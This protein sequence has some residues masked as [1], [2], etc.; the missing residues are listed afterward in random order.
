VDKSYIA[1]NIFGK[2]IG[3]V[4]TAIQVRGD[5]KQ[6][7]IARNRLG[8]SSSFAIANQN[9]LAFA[10]HCLAD[11]NTMTSGFTV[12][13]QDITFRNNRMKYEPI[14][15]P[16]GERPRGVTS[17]LAKFDA[18]MNWGGVCEDIRIYDNTYRG[19]I[20]V[21]RPV[22]GLSVHDNILVMAGAGLDNDS[23][24]G[25]FGVPHADEEVH[26]DRNLY[27][28]VNTDTGDAVDISEWLKQRRA[29]GHDQNSKTGDP[30]F[31]SLEAESPDFLKPAPGGPGEGLGARVPEWEE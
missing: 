9:V 27:H 1:D 2:D 3:I 26:S 31:K 30:E 16:E 22:N 20:L 25:F 24:R 7:V 28:A 17:R 15:V 6:A 13:A 21:D 10:H 29:A 4:K 11:G 12:D 18:H 5:T 14:E 19:P 23:F 8:E